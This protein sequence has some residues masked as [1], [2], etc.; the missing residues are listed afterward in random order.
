MLTRP[1]YFLSEFQYFGLVFELQK[2][3]NAVP[4][5]EIK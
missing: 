1:G 4:S 3:E 5:V 2:A